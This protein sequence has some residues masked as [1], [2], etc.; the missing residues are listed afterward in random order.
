MPPSWG[1]STADDKHSAIN[2]MKIQYNQ[3]FFDDVWFSPT[4]TPTLASISSG[5]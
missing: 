4:R 1:G 5:V 2:T 3:A